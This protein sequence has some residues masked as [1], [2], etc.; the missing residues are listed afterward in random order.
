MTPV[1][2]MWPLETLPDFIGARGDITGR[3]DV[4][5]YNFVHAGLL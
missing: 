1:L 2:L 5:N 4:W 3:G